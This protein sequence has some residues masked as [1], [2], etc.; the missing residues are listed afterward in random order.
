MLQPRSK[1]QRW[2]YSSSPRSSWISLCSKPD[3]EVFLTAARKLG[4][5]PADCVVIEAAKA[6]I[7]AAKAGGITAFA[8]LATQRAAVWRT[9]ISIP[10]AIF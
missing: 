6:G 9:M 10:S 3:P 5:A 4:T 2:T 1:L 7:E 8:L